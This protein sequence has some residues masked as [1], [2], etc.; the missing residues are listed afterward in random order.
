MSTVFYIFLA[1]QERI[2]YNSENRKKKKTVSCLRS[3]RRALIARTGRKTSQRIWKMNYKE[4]VEYI[5]SSRWFGSKR[6]LESFGRFLASLGEPQKKLRCIHIAGTNG[7]GSCAAMC[8]SVL[9]AAGYRTGLFTSPYLHR[10][11]ERMQMNGKEI[12]DETL[13]EIATRVRAAAEKAEDH[14]TAFEMMTACAFLWFAEE[15][16]DIVVL[17]TGLGGRF[18]ATN[19]VE[20]PEVSIIMNIGLD[21]T[22]ILGSSIAE[23]AG[24]KAGI[25]KQG[26]DCVLY[27]QS[28]EAEEVIRNVCREKNAPLH[29]ADFSQIV[30]EF[31]SLEGQ[32]FSYK[33]T[34]YALPLLGAYQQR[35]ASVVIETAEVLRKKGWKIPP[36]ALEHG[37]Y[38]VSWPA[39]FEVLADDPYFVLD[40]GHNPQCASELVENL[41]HYFP[42]Q[43]H[44]ILSGVLRDKDY[45]SIFSILG[46]SGS[47]FVCITPDSPRA[48]PAEALADFLR[49]NGMKA[50][51][52]ETIADGVYEAVERAKKC[53]GMV[54]A[55]GSLYLAGPIREIFGCY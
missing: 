14:P 5:N 53:G 22:Q 55:A 26:C 44:I 23:I 42:E 12:G 24:E 16:C 20:K 40:G 48:L 38:A 7:K 11:N 54:C 34:P 17:E 51:A 50:T 2:E 1:E 39:R 18:D 28:R 13:A 15:K 4:S 49:R 9:K 47:E 27:Q 52:C 10:F 29:T 46:K 41:S 19:I 45:A 35:N 21:H 3:M 33:G 32:V 43:K 25:I 8:A 37:L 30:P 6:G 31:D 36:E